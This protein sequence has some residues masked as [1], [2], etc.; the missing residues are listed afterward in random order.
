MEI[1]A[2]KHYNWH[3]YLA[4]PRPPQKWLVQDLFSMGSS[5]QMNG[6]PYAGKT[7]LMA[8]LAIAVASGTPFL[9][10]PTTQGPVW[11][12]ELDKP[13]HPF[14]IQ[15][16][17]LTDAGH[18]HENIHFS[19]PLEL[20]SLYPWDLMKAPMQTYIHNMMLDLKPSLVIVDC[21]SRL[22]G[23]ANQ[24]Q[25]HEV[26]PFVQNLITLVVKHPT[27]PACLSLIHHASN[28]D[29]NKPRPTQLSG[30]GSGDIASQCDQVWYI[31]DN[32]LVVATHL[33]GEEAIP[34]RMEPAGW[35]TRR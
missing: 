1:K 35:W 30:R 24:N 6:I 13:D 23:N 8:N 21:L 20:R 25:Q 2:P 15:L 17:Q 18:S 29:P 10:K 5:V 7:L 34:M 31:R 28:P 14:S 32:Q 4:L 27:N 16:Q 9:G 19:D 12:L 11:F 26:G 22:T 33:G 3:E